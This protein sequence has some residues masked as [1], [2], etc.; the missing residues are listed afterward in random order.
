MALLCARGGLRLGLGLPVPAASLYRALRPPEPPPA[1]LLP[2]P[3]GGLRHPEA[4]RYS[5]RTNSRA[6]LSAFVTKAKDVNK[7]YEQYLEKTFPRF[8]QLYSRFMKGVQEFF[9]DAKEIRRIKQYMSENKIQFHQLPYRE[10]ERLRQFRR[11]LIK[12][13]PIGIIAIPPFANYV[14]FVLMYLFPRQ[15][16]IRHFWTPKQQAEFHDIYHGMRREVYPE[17]I[18]GLAHVSRFLADVQLRGQMLDLCHKVQKG[19][20]PEVA[21]LQTVRSLFTG[22]PFGIHRLR[23]Q[24]AKALSRVLFLTPYLPSAVLKYRLRSHA[25]EVQHLDRALMRLG[26]SELSDS[27]AQMACYVRGLNSIHLSPSQCRQWL[28]QWLQLSESLKDAEASLLVHSMVLLSAN[29]A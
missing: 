22:H 4:Y 7:K 12:A 25:A 18:D 8:Y 9:S 27:E 20:H 13:I 14:V 17:V 10:M 29:Y 1:L 2:L 19:S 3:H 28:E 15:L 23:V 5:T 11:D 26:V 24:Q 6:L 21:E 16:L